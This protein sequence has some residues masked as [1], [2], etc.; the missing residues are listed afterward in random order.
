MH[1]NTGLFLFIATLIIAFGAGYLYK[2][3]RTVQD[4]ISVQQDFLEHQ[5]V[6]VDNNLYRVNRVKKT[7]KP[8]RIARS[9]NGAPVRYSCDEKVAVIEE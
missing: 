1:I 7:F 2:S 4:V 3:T 9:S 8:C 5:L 6:M